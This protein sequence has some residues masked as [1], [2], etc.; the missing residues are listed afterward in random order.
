[1]GNIAS[2]A[3]VSMWVHGA[4]AVSLE[5][6]CRD[7]VTGDEGPKV[8]GVEAAGPPQAALARPQGHPKQPPKVAADTA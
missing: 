8:A 7:A 1:M 2:V 5:C 6:R 4:G 3:W